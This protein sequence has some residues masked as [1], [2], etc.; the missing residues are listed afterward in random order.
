M[1]KYSNN[2]SDS[3][4]K[5]KTPPLLPIVDEENKDVSKLDV[6][7]FTCRT[8]PGDATSPTYKINIQVLRGV[9]PIRL[10][11]EWGKTL[12]RIFDG[13]NTTTERN[14]ILIA[15][16]L[17]QGSALN[18]F[19]TAIEHDL[20]NKRSQAAQ[21]AAQNAANGAREQAF[22][23]EMARDITDFYVNDKSTIRAGVN[24]VVANVCP[25]KALQK[26]KRYLRR[27]CRKP[28]DM[29]IRDYITRI[30]HI[31]QEEIPYLRPFGT[32]QSLPEDEIVDIVVHGCPKSW[33]G[34]LDRQTKDPDSMTL[35]E[36]LT[37][38][39][40]LEQ[41]EVTQG[42]NQGNKTGKSNGN[43][44]HKK[45]KGNNSKGSSKDGKGGT[46]YCAAH[47]KNPS[48][49]TDECHQVKALAKEKGGSSKGKGNGNKSWK[50]ESHKCTAS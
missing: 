48:H 21:Q 27:E 22:D 44:N 35:N 45:G 19:N 46:K 32:N 6:R 5:K 31:N 14:M 9:E 10:T 37:F 15:K 50:S 33:T 38:F 17:L 13:T 28:R 1:A 49:T 3:S 20:T 34:E 30:N 25:T 39:E 12:F 41:A 36:I 43:N 23:T 18:A 42:D 47:G 2:G 29:K 40:G 16:E 8:N 11:I 4:D 7:S 26:V 24:N